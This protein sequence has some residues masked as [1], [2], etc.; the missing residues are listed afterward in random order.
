M[1]FS[2]TVPI[3]YLGKGQLISEWSKDFLAATTMLKMDDAQRIQLLPMYVSRTP[4]EKA[5]AESVSEETVYKTAI[6]EIKKLIDGE[7]ST[8]QLTKSFFDIQAPQDE[9]CTSVYFELYSKG[10]AAD[11][12]TDIIFKR[13]L[14]FFTIG[15]KF[16]VDHAAEIKAEMTKAQLLTVFGKFKTKLDKLKKPTVVAIKVETEEMYHAVTEERDE[17]PSWAKDLQDQISDMR[18]EMRDNRSYAEAS[19]EN[20]ESESEESEA[21]Y[22]SNKGKSHNYQSQSSEA[23]KQVKKCKIC[24][25]AG[26]YAETC[27]RRVCLKC[28]GKGHSDSECPSFTYKK[29]TFGQKDRQA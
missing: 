6:D 1:S 4:G 12:P 27:R 11:V 16:Y 2:A 25:K 19:Y 9:D 17:R 20:N 14:T 29:K 13:F 23:N 26:H 24:K 5:L 21:Y 15:D 22:Y 3:P 8:I 10:T 18:H 28:K 7:V